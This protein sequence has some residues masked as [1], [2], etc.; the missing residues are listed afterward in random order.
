MRDTPCEDFDNLWEA[1]LSYGDKAQIGHDFWL[2]RNGHGA[3]FWDGD[4][5]DYGDAI[6]QVVKDN[7]FGCDLCVNDDGQVEFI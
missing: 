7:F 6:T 4:Y 5:G 3:G 1:A 2:T